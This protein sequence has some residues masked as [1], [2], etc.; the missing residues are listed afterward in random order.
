M[1]SYLLIAIFAFGGCASMSYQRNAGHRYFDSGECL[2]AAQV[3]G[4]SAEKSQ[5]NKLL[6]LLDQGTALI[7]AMK[8]EEAINVFLEAEKIAEIK[9]YT[10][11]S[12]VTAAVVVN[13]NVKSY[14]GEDFE[15]V[16]INVYLALAFASLGKDED[17]LVEAR[18]INQILYRMINEGK[19]PYEENPFARYLSALLWENSGEWN[20]AYIDYKKTYDLNPNFP[21]IGEDLIRSA[22]KLGFRDELRKWKKEFPGNEKNYLAKNEGE[23]LIFYQQGKSPKKIPQHGDHNGLPVYQDRYYHH[24]KLR[25]VGDDFTEE[26]QRVVLDIAYL[27]KKYL[28]A[29]MGSLVGKKLLR[30]AVKGAVAAAVGKASDDENLGWLTFYALMAMDQEDM[31][32]WLTLPAEIVMLRKRLKEGKYNLKLELLLPNGS[33]YETIDI[34]EEYIRAGKKNFLFLK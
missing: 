27:S 2:R 23:L 5:A 8:Y 9:D 31:R 14:V 4:E 10:S 19:M 32:S 33:L 1:K 6:Y 26:E 22:S 17:A 11:I 24:L 34:D 30:T 25:L 20:D 3:Y 12:E 21:G 16:L 28:D 13:D 7:C 18:K 15:K 29:K